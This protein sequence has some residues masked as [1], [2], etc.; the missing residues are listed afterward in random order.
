MLR[1]KRNRRQLILAANNAPPSLDSKENPLHPSDNYLRD[2][3]MTKDIPGRIQTGDEESEDSGSQD[4]RF[5]DVPFDSLHG[6]QGTQ[7]SILPQ[8]R[9]NNILVQNSPEHSRSSILANDNS[10]S[11]THS[12]TSST[13]STRSTRSTRSTDNHE[14]NDNSDDDDSVVDIQLIYCQHCEKSYAP[15]TYKKFC[16]T[17]DEN[18]TPKCI[19]MRNKKRKVYNSAKVRRKDCSIT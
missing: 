13:S 10:I 16:Q 17:L 5:D 14:N 7:P 12:N 3:G 18:G 11:S 8:E 1:R 6:I 19:A 9:S 2:D 15:A 4:S